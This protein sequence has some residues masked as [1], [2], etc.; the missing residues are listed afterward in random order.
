MR[1]I[2][3]NIR[4]RFSQSRSEGYTPADALYRAITM[5]RFESLED[6][7]LV[8]FR[9]I[10]DEHYMIEN[11]EGDCFEPSCNPGVSEKTL[12]N[13]RKE[14]HETIDR[15]GV[16]SLVGEYRIIPFECAYYVHEDEQTGWTTGDAV[17]GFVGQD[18][19][20]YTAD[21][22]AETIESLKNELRSRCSQCRKA[23]S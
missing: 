9:W 3:D 21:I 2:T 5:D 4:K 20:V 22:A 16:W 12:E 14:F 15:E 13:R 18:A 17:C 10:A 8:R 1:T 23:A 11:L 7:G 6:A 19:H